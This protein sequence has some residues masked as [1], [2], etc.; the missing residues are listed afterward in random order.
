MDWLGSLPA[1]G[2]ASSKKKSGEADGE[3]D[4]GSDWRVGCGRRWEG[5][6]CCD[7][8]NWR[9]EALESDIRPESVEESVNEES[10]E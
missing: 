8:W 10:P 6:A 2:E 7:C 5:E 9:E 1:V 3:G 4:W